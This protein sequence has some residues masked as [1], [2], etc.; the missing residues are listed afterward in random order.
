MFFAGNNNQGGKKKSD[1][2]IE[3]FNCHKKGHKRV[4]FW[5]KRGKKE[6]QG[7][8]SKL[9][10]NKEESKKEMTSAVVEEGV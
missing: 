9:K 7:P 8:R 4:D 2:D 10:K 3:C 5:T 1:K 6:G